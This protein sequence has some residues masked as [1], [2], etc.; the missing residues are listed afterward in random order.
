MKKLKDALG[1]FFLRRGEYPKVK[2]SFIFIRV[3]D[4][5]RLSLGK[6]IIMWGKAWLGLSAN[7]ILINLGR[8]VCGK[9]LS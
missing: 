7:G 8:I 3:L 6:L 4:F 1:I 5:K 9:N 2:E